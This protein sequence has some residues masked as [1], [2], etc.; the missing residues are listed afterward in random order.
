VASELTLA[1]A[2]FAS[3]NTPLTSTRTVS[4]P[5]ETGVAASSASIA[6]GRTGPGGAG[7]GGEQQAGQ[8][9]ADVFMASSLQ[10]GPD[11]TVRAGRS[12]DP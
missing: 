11:R 2:Y 4:S 5:A 10:R 12:L 7:R 6:I 9:A 8:H 1:R 3:S